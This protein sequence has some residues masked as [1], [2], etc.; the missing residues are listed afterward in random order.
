MSLFRE[1]GIGTGMEQTPLRRLPILGP[2]PFD[3]NQGALSRAVKVMLEGG[4]GDEIFLFHDAALC[5]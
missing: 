1:R 2:Q 5:P 4:E 3:M